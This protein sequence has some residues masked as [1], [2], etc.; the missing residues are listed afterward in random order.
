MLNAPLVLAPLTPCTRKVKVNHTRSGADV[1]ILEDGTEVGRGTRRGRRLVHRP[2]C[3][4]HAAA[5]GRRVTRPSG[6]AV[7]R[8]E[9]RLGRR[10]DRAGNADS[11]HAR[12]HRVR[13]RLLQCGVCLWLE[14]IVPGAT[15]TV[16][17]GGPTLSVVA[18]WTAVHVDL[19]SSGAGAIVQVRQTACGVSR[20]CPCRPRCA[21]R[22]TR[23][24][25][26]CADG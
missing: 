16:Q 22:S 2:P 1:F 18:D 19:P 26:A 23:H 6:A 12:R 13:K 7:N 21:T 9:T 11:R 24:G 20:G 14:G 17:S 8:A 15:V 4:R 3:G 10:G 5:A 25:P